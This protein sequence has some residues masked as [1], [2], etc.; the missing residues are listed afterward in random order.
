MQASFDAQLLLGI[1]GHLKN[2]FKTN[3]LAL[4]QDSRPRVINGGEVPCPCQASANGSGHDNG[5]WDSMLP[6]QQYPLCRHTETERCVNA[7]SRNG[8][9]PQW[10]TC[11]AGCAAQQ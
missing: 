4:T 1:P 6:Q 2:G 11:R 10:L 8:V 5:N 9:L 7:T 3:S